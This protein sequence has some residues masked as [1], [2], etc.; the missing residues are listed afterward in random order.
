MAL[1]ISATTIIL[2]LSC[3]A[4]ARPQACS[5][6]SDTLYSSQ[7]YS[8]TASVSGSTVT[9]LTGQSFNSLTSTFSIILA[10]TS[11][12]IASITN[13]NLLTV[14]GSP[15]SSSGEAWTYNVPLMAGST[16]TFAL[17][18][19]PLPIVQ[20]VA[21]LTVA[22]TS[23][24]ITTCLPPATYTASYNVLQ[25]GGGAQSFARYWNVPSGTG[26]FTVASYSGAPGVETTT[27]PNP[28]F[29][30]S[31]Q[32][33]APLGPSNACLVMNSQGTAA[34]WSTSCSGPPPSSLKLSTLT[35]AQLLSMTNAQLLTLT[36]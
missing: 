23:P 35:N 2:L 24:N 10:G 32:Q 28:N 29:T 3:A 34:V 31:L 4:I 6:I 15:S 9:R 25:P 7:S 8:G 16:I 26:P 12:P 13:G 27:P 11:Y 1:R 30:I 33:I 5:N 14:T 36:N 17:G 20:S 22:S 18:Y 19:S 21:S